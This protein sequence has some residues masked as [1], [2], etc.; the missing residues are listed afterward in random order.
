VKVLV[1]D[2][3]NRV[4][5]AVVRALGRAGAEVHVVEQERFAARTPAAFVSRHV[6][7]REVVPSLADEA[8]FV[9]ALARRAEGMDVVLPISTN[10]V[11]ACARHRG[12]IPAKLPI[13]PL[14]T[15]RRAN[16]K[17]SAL[18]LAR[19]AG[20]AVP[21][22]WAPESEE[23]LEEV[24]ASVRLPAIVKLRDDEGTT[25]DPGERYAVCATSTDVASAWRRLHRLKPFPLVQERVTGD[26]YGVG[27]V[28]QDGKVLASV[29]HRRIREYPI[30]GGPS[31]LCETVKDADLDAAAAAMAGALNWTGAAMVEFKKDDRYRLM[32]VNPRFWGSLPLALAAGVNLPNVLCRMAMGEDAG[33]GPTARAGVRLRFLALDAA[34]AFQGLTSGR[35][36]T[37]LAFLRD[38]FDPTIPDGILDPD[39]LKASLVYLSNR[40]P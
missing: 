10:V 36:S 29:A 34:A 1:T 24:A 19:K 17:S 40:L 8:A 21:A 39:D 11:L 23:E 26:G 32:E 20:V 6:S 9:D 3:A 28:A 7:T 38:L 30:T 5:L 37:T 25:L 31:T 12:R 22:T 2:A 18:A 4:A 14:E 13:S 15:I 33:G 16:D 35:A 27:L